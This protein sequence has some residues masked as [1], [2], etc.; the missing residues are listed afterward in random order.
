MVS[1]GIEM[2]LSE[3]LFLEISNNINDLIIILNSD[4]IIEFINEMVRIY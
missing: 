4:F 3:K 2:E 1:L